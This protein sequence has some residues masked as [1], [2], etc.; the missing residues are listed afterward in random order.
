[1]TNSK[2]SKFFS[3]LKPRAA[4]TTL[5]SMKVDNLAQAWKPEMKGNQS[6]HCWLQPNP[7][8]MQWW[9]RLPALCRSHLPSRF[10][11]ERKPSTGCKTYTFEQSQFSL[12]FP[13]HSVC[14]LCYWRN[15]EAYCGNQ[16]GMHKESGGIQAS[17]G[18]NVLA[19]QQD[20]HTN[21]KRKDLLMCSLQRDRL[22][23]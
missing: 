3:P 8:S 9:E 13:F 18:Q 15:N 17:K 12:W 14:A 1:M 2:G 4:Q 5:P 6:M 21:S 22:F 10:R 16:M 20:W 7:W 19:H 11:Q 23:S